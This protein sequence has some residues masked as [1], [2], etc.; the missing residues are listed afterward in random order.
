MDAS[1]H[2]FDLPTYRDAYL[3]HPNLEIFRYAA[4][5]VQGQRIVDSFVNLIHEVHSAF[6]PNKGLASEGG[7]YEAFEYENKRLIFN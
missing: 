1:S 7:F 6:H 5:P 2:A 4:A 3:I